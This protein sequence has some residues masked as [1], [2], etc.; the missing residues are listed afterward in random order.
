MADRVDADDLPFATPDY[1]LQPPLLVDTLSTETS[2]VQQE[3]V[4]EC[5]PFLGAA[6]DPS[7]NPLEFNEFGVPDLRKED[8]VTFLE[9]NLARFP[10]HF[11]GLDASRPWMVYWGLI[12]LYLLGEDITLKRGR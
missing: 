6:I 3:T 10:A 5:R 9:H 11:V 4:D 7:K 8:H 12:A 1:F 2:E